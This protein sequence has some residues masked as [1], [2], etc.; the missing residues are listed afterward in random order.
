MSRSRVDATGTGAVLANNPRFN[1]RSS[2]LQSMDESE[3]DPPVRQVNFMRDSGL[4]IHRRVYS[5]SR[6]CSNLP[7][8]YLPFI[9]CVA[10]PWHG[11]I[12]HEER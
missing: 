11:E 10:K 9:Y 3:S 12:Y 1:E 8:V 6:F 5:Y 4:C 7:R 2:L